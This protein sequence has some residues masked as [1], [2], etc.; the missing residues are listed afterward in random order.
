MPQLAISKKVLLTSTR[1]HKSS[2]TY[3]YDKTTGLK[4]FGKMAFVQWSDDHLPA[5][6]TPFLMPRK[7]AV[8]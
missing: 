5:S 8:R 2:A 4:L 6:R 3:V 7:L 1:S